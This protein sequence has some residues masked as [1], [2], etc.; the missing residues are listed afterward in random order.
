MNHT[1]S[2]RFTDVERL[3]MEAMFRPMS[4]GGGGGITQLTGDVTAGP[5][6]GSQVAEVVG[7]LSEPLPFLVPGY[8]NW[9]GTQ[10]AFTPIVGG[11][12][13]LSSDVTAGPG[14]GNQAA[15]VVGILSHALPALSTGFLNWTGAAW[16]FTA[17]SAGITQL[18]GDGTAGPGSGS[19]ALTVVSAQ[20]GATT[21]GSGAL[22]G[23]ITGYLNNANGTGYCLGAIGNSTHWTA[24]TLGY[25]NTFTGEGVTDHYAVAFDGTN[26]LLNAIVG[27]ELKLQVGGSGVTIALATANGFQIGT[28]PAFG[29]GT[30]V[31]GLNDATTNPTTL[32]AGGVALY[33]SAVSSGQGLILAG[34]AFGFPSFVPTPFIGQFPTSTVAGTTLFVQA[35]STTA[36]GT[37]GGTLGLFSGSGGSG[38]LNGTVEIG[39]GGTG[40]PVQFTIGPNGMQWVPDT[41]ALA[42]TGTTTLTQPEYQFPT[43]VAS[44]VTLT[45]AV[46]IVFPNVSGIWLLDLSNVTYAGNSVTVQSGTATLL[47]NTS[48]VSAGTQIFFVKANGSNGITAK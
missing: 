43:L 25:A 28:T 15:E 5:G 31:L 24:L 14:S 1:N 30:G 46:T 19:Q 12:T 13:Q 11:I 4:S 38:G 22:N 35:Q 9:T 23:T 27:G 3:A 41:F 47:L 37:N 34:N 40:G 45:G 2:N 17:V 20:N 33:A 32:P 6:V 7:I 39:T 21:F 8:L 36:A 42:A 29:G 10:W 18:T 16:A 44:T 48:A 26:T